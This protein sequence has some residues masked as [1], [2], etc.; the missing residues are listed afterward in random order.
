MIRHA[1]NGAGNDAVD[2]FRFAATVNPVSYLIECVRSL[3][4]TGWDSTA[5]AL[6]FGFAALLAVAIPIVA[7]V[8]STL[9][10]GYKWTATAAIG[11]TTRTTTT[12]TS[13]PRSSAAR[14]TAA[15]IF[16]LERFVR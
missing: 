6:G 5:L 3:I 13:A 14:A 10:E 15:P 9:F 8:L 11:A 2:W 1:P 16:P 12:T 4:I 7:M